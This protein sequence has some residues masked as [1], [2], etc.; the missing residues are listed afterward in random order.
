MYDY[1]DMKYFFSKY[2]ENLLHIACL[3]YQENL[4]CVQNI[5]TSFVDSVIELK[6][7]IQLSIITKI[8]PTM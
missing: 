2:C 7:A 5:L 8:L 1:I 3:M 4:K 6:Y